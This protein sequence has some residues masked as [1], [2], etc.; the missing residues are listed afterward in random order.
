MEEEAGKGNTPGFDIRSV[1]RI[2]KDERGFY[3]MEL[4]RNNNRLIQSSLWLVGSNRANGDVGFMLYNKNPMVPGPSE[5]RNVVGYIVDYASKAN[6]TEKKSR[7]NMETLI[8]S[9]QVTT[10]DRYD[11]SSVTIKCMNQLMKHKMTSKQETVCLIAGLKLFDCSNTIDKI[12]INGYKAINENGQLTSSDRLKDYA[13]RKDHLD[14]SY[15][16]YLCCTKNQSAQAKTYI[17]HFVGKHTRAVY[18]ITE[19]YA[20]L[21][22]LVYMPWTK[23]FPETLKKWKQGD[24]GGGQKS[25]KE[26]YEKFLKT[27][28]CPAIVK[29]EHKRAEDH[30]KNDYKE[31]QVAT[32]N[33]PPELDEGDINIDPDT[34]EAVNLYSTLCADINLDESEMEKLDTGLNFDWTNQRCLLPSGMSGEDA[35]SWL[36]TRVK[37]SNDGETEN[38]KLEIPTKNDGSTYEPEQLNEDQVQ[39]FYQ[40]MSSVRKWIESKRESKEVK[41]TRKEKFNQLL[42]T[43]AGVGGSGKSTLVKTIITVIRRIFQINNSALVAA[44]TGSASFNGGGVTMHRLF[45]LPVGNSKQE[46]GPERQNKLRDTFA[47]IVLLVI[48]ERSMIS[49]QDFAMIDE[50]A[51]LVVHRGRN[52]KEHFGGIPIVLLVGDDYQ[53]PPVM[54]GAAF[55]YAR[56]KKDE[57]DEKNGK[58]IQRKVNNVRNENNRICGGKLFELIGRKFMTLSTSKR[59]L[60]NEQL[61]TDCLKGVRGDYERPISESNIQR[62]MEFHIRSPHFTPEMVQE[63]ENDPKTIHLFSI[64]EDKDDHNRRKLKMMNCAERPVAVIWSITENGCQN[65]NNRGHYDEERTPKSTF[66]CVGCKVALVGKNIKPEWG[67]YHG[68]IGFV[69]DIVYKNKEGPH[70]KG[71]AED[72]LPL[73]V[74]V[75]FPQYCG[76]NMYAEDDTLSEKEKEER[77]T[78]VCISMEEVRCNNNSACGRLYMPLSLA[79]ARTIHSFQGASVGKTPPGQPDNTF[80]RIIADPGT[81]RFEGRASGLFYTLLSRATTLGEVGK[82]ETSAMLFNGPNMTP[83]RIRAIKK[84]EDG[85]DYKKIQDLKEW[86]TYLEGNN[87]DPVGD[88]EI[89]DIQEWV[90][91]AVKKPIG[92]EEFDEWL[93]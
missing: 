23:S 82:P 81:R 88:D 17:P 78:W 62:L 85:T 14:K 43:V 2:V 18:P 4:S 5:I 28:N 67:L 38:K 56:K 48:D 9:H 59:V 51:K 44:P 79:F 64:N 3:R 89:D 74:M 47:N 65:R 80:H 32:G 27:K 24:E 40:V 70:F 16:E 53:L 19:E 6:E 22:L 46:M 58:A 76:P 41:S 42:M 66:F 71:K 34:E 39:V 92:K 55:M 26:L 72:K 15:Y 90:R 25:T 30:H 33:D 86:V 31:P 11:V 45:G 1:A 49:A 69:L 75:N 52:P 84:S 54:P 13:H 37:S 20:T 83:S 87:I 21:V 93:D 61:L 7:E 35:G 12:S 73:Y 68:A 60:E 50:H 29:M 57:N 36:N 77:R 10:G 8:M 63:L 91:E